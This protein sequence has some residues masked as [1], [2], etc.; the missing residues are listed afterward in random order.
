MCPFVHRKDEHH[1]LDLYTVLYSIDRK[2]CEISITQELILKK[3]QRL[4]RQEAKMATDL[5]ALT[6]AVTRDT[7]VSTSAIT[8]LNHLSELLAASATDPAAIQSI[9]ESL[10]ANADALAAAVVA[11]TPAA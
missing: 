7:E 4:T 6:A 8:L 9:A 10:T 2:L 11:N 1:K 3:L 5:T